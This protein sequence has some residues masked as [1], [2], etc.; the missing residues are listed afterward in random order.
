MRASE[1][2][3]GLGG[4][5]DAGSGV[6]VA[7]ID[8]GIDVTSPFFDDAGYDGTAQIDKCPDQDLDTATDNTN[9]KVIVCRVYASGSAGENDNPALFFDHGTHVAG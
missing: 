1:V 2:W 5:A 9:N 3:G 8:T 7:I 4:E 6:K